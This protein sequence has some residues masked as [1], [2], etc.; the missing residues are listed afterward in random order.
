MVKTAVE[1]AGSAFPDAAV[2][3]A[4]VIKP[5]DEKQVAAIC[6]SSRAIVVLEEHSVFGGLGSAITEIVAQFAQTRVLR[7]GVQ[8]RFSHMCG[9]Y[10][11]LLQEHGLDRSAVEARVKSFAQGT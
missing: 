1:I 5:L 4:P 10:E 11:Y 8:D 6:T 9:T 3:S 7:I 2:W